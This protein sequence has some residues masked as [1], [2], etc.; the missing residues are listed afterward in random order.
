MLLAI[1]PALLAA[2]RS[3]Q[4]F[5]DWAPLLAF[6]LVYDRLRLMQPLLLDRVAVEGAFNIERWAFGW[7]SGGDAPAHA[8]RAFLQANADSSIWAAISWAAQLVYLSHI[9]VFPLLMIIWWVRGK[10]REKDREQFIRHLHAFTVVNLLGILLY[11]AV[12]VAPPWWVSLYGTAQPSAALVAQV[13]IP[14][15][16]DGIII[17]RLIQTAPNWFAAVPSLHG[18]YCVLLLLLAIGRRSRFVIALLAIYSASMWTAT[19]IL[20]QHYI[21]DLLAGG[22]L[23]LLAFLYVEWKQPEPGNSRN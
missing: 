9:I 5:L 20:N 3:R 13:K 10:L 15:A 8:A 19:V 2:E 11:L 21:I 4:F 12:P 23:A 17:Q 14:D 1:P 18:A 6:W 16:M 7:L 22:A